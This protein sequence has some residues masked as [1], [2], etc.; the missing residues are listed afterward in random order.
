MIG[1]DLAVAEQ[2][3]TSGTTSQAPDCGPGWHKPLLQ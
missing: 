2:E 1:I 3:Y